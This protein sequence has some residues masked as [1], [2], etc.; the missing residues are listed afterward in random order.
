MPPVLKLPR[1]SRITQL[2]HKGGSTYLVYFADITSMTDA[3]KLVGHYCLV[4]KEDLPEGWDQQSGSAFAGVVVFDLAE[5]QLGSVTRVEENP[6]H[7][8]LVVD[9]QGR[10]VLI[11]LV[12]DFIVNFDEEAATLT[13]DLP[14]GMLDSSTQNQERAGSRIR[15]EPIIR[16][17]NF[18]TKGRDTMK[19]ETL[20]VFPH[21]YD[22]IMNESIMKRAQDKGFLDFYAYDLRD[23]THEKHRTTDDEPY[24]GGQGLVMKCEPIFEA[25]DD[26]F[27]RYETKPYVIFLSPTGTRFDDAKSVELA[28]KDHLFF[29]C[30]HYEGIDE[31]AYTL[32]DEVLSIGDYV[33]TSGE[34]ASMVII[35]A[36][37]RRIDGVLG[38]EGSAVD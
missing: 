25:T 13:L 37:V 24:G 18:M 14:Q 4:R 15:A 28:Q 20:S 26:I 7:P 30:G 35:D 21:C 34:L 3:E 33:L 32:A 38:D 1:S 27:A 10:N 12:D 5:G 29:I 6:A 31:R 22:S 23:W 2:D 16:T 36:V 11:P 17:E 9:Y 8:L 19:I